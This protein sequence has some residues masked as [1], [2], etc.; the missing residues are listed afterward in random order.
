MRRHFLIDSMFCV[1]L[2]RRELR[3]LANE[4]CRGRGGL[5]A[6]CR[7]PSTSTCDVT[8]NESL[9]Y[10]PKELDNRSQLLE[11]IEDTIEVFQI[12]RYQEQE[13]EDHLDMDIDT[14]FA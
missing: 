4:K 14:D 11:E 1:L 12:P 8:F 5:C 6:V 7:C 3:E 2:P 10:D 9:F 13:E